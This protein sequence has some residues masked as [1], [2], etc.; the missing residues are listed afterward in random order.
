MG[1]RAA[2]VDQPP[3]LPSGHELG[4]AT[5]TVGQWRWRYLEL[6]VPG[7]QDARR[8][9]RPRTMATPTRVQ[10]IAM[11][12]AL[13]PDQSRTGTRWTLAEM[14][15]AFLDALHTEA[16]SRS[17]GWRSLHD[18]DLTPHKRA[19]WLQRHEADCETKA[20]PIC[21]LDVK[22][23]AASPQGRL[24]ICGDAKTGRQGLERKAPTQPAHPGRRARRE[25]ADI[26][27]GTQVLRKALAVA[28]GQIAWTMGAT[29]QATDFGAH[30]TQASPWWPGR[31]RD[32]WVMD[33][34]HTH[35]SLAVCRLVAQWG[36]GPFEPRT[37]QTGPQ[38]R[39]LRTDPSHRHG[40]HCPPKHGSWLN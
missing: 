10:G 27:H 4:W 29:R 21:H 20:R 3:N 26:R 16:S 24:G 5:L 40:F 8:S 37:L 39:A 22:A 11:A 38:R 18:V 1:L 9:G 23:R 7:W 14:V 15:A 31:R 17:S 13:P 28:T 36:Q 25:P 19:S 6:G 35:G 30:L 33:N 32:A 34:L 12:R 2:A